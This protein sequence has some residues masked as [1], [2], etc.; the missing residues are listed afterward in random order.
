MIQAAL[1]PVPNCVVFPGMVFP[2]HV[3]E[4]RYRAM[5]K[6]CLD[7]GVFMGVCHTQKMVRA[8][9]KNQSLKEALNSNQATYKPHSV[10]S[11]GPCELVKTFEDGRMR[12]NMHAQVRLR[13]VEEVQ[14]LPFSI[15]ACE[16]Y[17]D[18]GESA[19]SRKDAEALKQKTL[20]R[21][22]AL[23]F[24]IPQ[25]REILKAD[26]W[27]NKQPADFSF[28]LFRILQLPAAIQQKIL[29][30]KSAAER[31]AITLTVLNRIS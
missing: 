3:F 17:K 16:E 27:K 1:F 30:R 26:V 4:P 28:Q 21:L 6:H 18:E 19:Q 12:I 2:L 10:F 9:K 20:R 14:T 13:A 8:G 25:L 15:C 31:L 29:E 11:A 7:D 22:R 24:S 23:T 5:V